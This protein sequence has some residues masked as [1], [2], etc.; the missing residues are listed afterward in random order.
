MSTIDSASHR[1]FVSTKAVYSWSLVLLLIS[2]A[3]VA[4]F[5]AH[6]DFHT[7]YFSRLER[8][9]AL[10]AL[11]H[12]H[13][14]VHVIGFRIGG[15]LGRGQVAIRFS[16]RHLLLH[17]ALRVPVRVG[18]LRFAALLPGVLLGVVP[19]VAGALAGSGKLLVI[20]ALMTAAAGG[21]V[22]VVAA[23]RG[24]EAETRVELGAGWTS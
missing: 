12:G 22:A 5:F 10:P 13:E 3:L 20:G 4:P 7:L 24:L 23:V 19:L 18:R 17:V 9:V 15:G 21:D 8:L 11:L 16:Y 14:L 1:V 2:G 6:H